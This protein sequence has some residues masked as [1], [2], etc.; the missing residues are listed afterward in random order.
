MSMVHVLVVEDSPTQA[1]RL[2]AD[3]EAGGFDVLLARSA[4]EALRRLE[5]A[6][7]DVIA[8]DVVMPGMTGYELCRKVKDDPRLR[9]IPVILLTSLTDPLEVVNGL[10]AG[11]DNFLRKPYEADQLIARLRTAVNNRE[12]RRS[13]RLQVG[14]Q[15]SFLDREFDITA[16]RQQILDLLISTFE[17]LVVTSRTVRQREE[18]LEAAHAELEQQLH[19]VELERQRLRAVVDAVP[20]PLF[21]TAP[22][23]LISHASEASALVLQ[24][25]LAV[26]CG[27]RLDDVACFVDAEGKSVPHHALPHNRASEAGLPSRHGEAFD[28]FV[29][30]PDGVRTPVVL[31]ASPI[32]DEFAR[33]AGCVAT[34]HT[35]G[36]LTEHDP[37]TGLPNSAAF[38]ARAA[39]LLEAH[40]GRAG[41]L[42][43][44]L[45]RFDVTQ[46]SLSTSARD[47]VLLDTARRLRPV[48]ESTRGTESQ[49][50]CQLA[51][52]GGH[53][54]GVLLNNLPDS[55]RVV[56]LADSARR[57]ISSRPMGPD[58]VN[59][60]ASVGIAL[61][62][63]D[64]QGTALFA[65]AGAALRN[66][67]ELGGN[68]VETLGA[69]AAKQAMDQLRL[70][71]DLRA[72]VER[73]EISLHFQPEYDLM[74][75]ELI[76]FEAL[77]RWHHPQFGPVAPPVFISLAEQ[78]GII[79]PLG[80][81]ILRKACAAAQSW[82]ENCSSAPLTIAVNVSAMQL[83]ASLVHEVVGV[84]NETG[85][86]PSRLMLE[87][88]ETA[89]LLDPET[90][91]P[92][93]EELRHIGVR[94]ALDDFGT[95]YSSLTQLT[96]I[97][98][99][100]L[101]LD[102]GFVEAIH[103]GGTDAIIG[104]SVIALGLALDI[105]VL[106]EGVET[107]E[108]AQE[109]RRLGAP[110]CQGYLFSK[111]LPAEE[112]LGFLEEH[113]V[114]DPTGNLGTASRR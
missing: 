15:L 29:Q 64:Q 110:L 42:I 51:Y 114:T 22:D 16:D 41:L 49:S 59:V 36:G 98:F 103:L 2:C 6:E 107:E 91:V 69:S 74:S 88:T 63:G 17:E 70:E 105:P 47:G 87:I 39:A 56:H 45:D 90:T 5:D 85:L 109:L 24:K 80:Q 8:S 20:V 99:D 81:Q 32:L 92:I 30:R 55:F 50:D 12:L 31:E 25:D 35:V 68:R 1:A 108:Q 18:E 27:S 79:H 26:I 83:R 73:D 14:V 82:P 13:G 72:A 11:A 78:S 113:R 65:A 84:L 46:A 60:T 104:R 62:D 37:L 106:A 93:V 28:L 44:E 77:A 112:V 76:G 66:A 3:L 19:L 101:K 34:A 102:R 71:I 94:F 111:P 53:R 9:D 58:E 57:A 61:D 10:E 21:V 100:Q 40:H 96:K 33:S 95:G 89:S 97:D 54:Y 43:L 4:S 38:L 86:D 7:V 67:Q 52:L 23:G 48:F 75:G